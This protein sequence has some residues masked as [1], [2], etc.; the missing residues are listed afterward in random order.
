ML[1]SVSANVIVQSSSVL[2]HAINLNQPFGEAA[3]AVQDAQILTQPRR[4]QIQRG[5]PA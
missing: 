3:I 5:V 2:N 1:L 4:A